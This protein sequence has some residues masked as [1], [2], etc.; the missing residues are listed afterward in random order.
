MDSHIYGY[1]L[2]KFNHPFEP[3]Q[4]PEAADRHRVRL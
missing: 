1:T 3:E 2:Q 4:F